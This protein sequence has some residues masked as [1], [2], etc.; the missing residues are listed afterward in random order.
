MQNNAP[1]R[2][3]L[4]ASSAH[5]S[6]FSHAVDRTTHKPHN[7]R[8]LEL[9]CERRAK[10]VLPISISNL[11]RGTAASLIIA[12]FLALTTWPAVAESRFALVIGNGA[13]KSVPALANPPNDA[14]DVAAALKSLG[15][16]VTLKIDLDLA[17]MQRAIDE[18]AVAVGRRRRFPLLLRRTRPSARGPQLPRSRRRRV[19]HRSTISR[20]RR[21]R[22]IPCWPSSARETAVTSSFSTPAATIPSPGRRHA[23]RRR[24]WRGSA[25][26]PDSSSR[27]RRSPTTSPSTEAAATAPSPQRCSVTS[28]R[29]APTSPA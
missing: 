13:Y 2:A 17:A 1:V 11:L 25:S 24:D 6:T 5:Q 19:A 4:P 28:R 9:A 16:K 14:Q 27:S 18:F 29:P 12:C 15:F 26:F 21:S 22:S 7:R 8:E 3:S 10:R 20:R 23:A